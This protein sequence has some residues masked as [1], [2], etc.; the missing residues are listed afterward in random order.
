MA[1]LVAAHPLL[2]GLP[3]DAVNEVAGCARNMAY[4]AGALLI[5]DGA[6]ADTLYLVRRGRVAIEVQAPGT[7]TI[8]IETVGPGSAVGWSW[9][10]PP[11]RSHFYARAVDPVG[12]VAVDGECLRLKAATD[13]ALGY[14]LMTR[15]AALLLERLHAT[16]TRLLELHS[17]DRAP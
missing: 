8:V 11:Y 16:Q 6:P 13:P 15:I 5:R 2:A 17:A 10:W 12:A 7:G 1:G 3:G 4:E 14:A 9:L